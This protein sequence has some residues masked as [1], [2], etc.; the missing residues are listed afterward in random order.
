MAFRKSLAWMSLTRFSALVLQFG[1][2]VVMAHYLSPSQMGVFAVASATAGALSILQ[3]LGLQSLIVREIDLSPALTATAFTINTLISIALSAAIF[4]VSFLGGAFLHDEGVRRVL[5]VLAVTPLIAIF[6]FLPE[7]NLERRGEFKSMALVGLTSAILSSVAMIILAILG[8]NYMS[9]AY[10]AW[11]STGAYA[12]IINIVGRKHIS[13]KIDFTA[14]RRVAEFGLQMLAVSGINSLSQRLS[15]VAMGRLQG[16]SQLGIYNRAT[17][18]NGLIWNNFHVVVGRVVFVDLAQLNQQGISLRE[19]YLRAIEIV[20]ALLWPAFA[21]FAILA[22]PFIVAVYGEKWVAAAQPMALLAIASMVSVATS[23]TWELFAAKGELKAQ[24]R[25]E[26]IRAILSILLFIGGC[27]IS[28]TA[29]AT[30]RIA[31]AVFA[32]F[33]YRPHLNRMTDTSLPDFIP[34]FGRS[35]LLTILAITPAAVL[36]TRQMS[37]RAPLWLAL[38]CAMIGVVLWA[39]GL[40]AMEHPLK[41]EAFAILD[42]MPGGSRLSRLISPV[43]LTGKKRRFPFY[44]GA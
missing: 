3:A 35:A 2:S 16:L 10:A 36:M 38:V 22:G 24:T 43:R 4:G 8:F 5:M 12:V 1:A 28:L 18:L 37:A 14:W 15:D 13:F 26:F 25:I 29:A 27:M 11:V 20:T 30:A 33:L 7:S 42:R 34:I 32:F 44:P 9:A 41:Q 31:D 19:R 17:S 21:G 23:M 40:I 6:D 39:V